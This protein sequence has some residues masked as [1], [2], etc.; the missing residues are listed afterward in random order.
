MIGV[1]AELD[2]TQSGKVI[3]F[4]RIKKET[5]TQ[6]K[7][8]KPERKPPEKEP[9]PPELN[10]SEQI[11]PESGSGAGFEPT[12]DGTALSGGPGLGNLAS[13]DTEAVP[14]VRVPPEY[15]QR[16]AQRGIEGWVELEF[17]ISRAGTVKAPRV[18]GYEPSTVFNKAALRAIKKWKYNPKIEE[19]KAVEQPGIQVRLRFA[20]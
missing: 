13:A 3:D 18:I 15:P 7:E 9:P 16:A 8:R 11:R 20:L 19:G 17:T 12:F 10:V 14:L 1:D 6:K 5:Q 4:V 2:D